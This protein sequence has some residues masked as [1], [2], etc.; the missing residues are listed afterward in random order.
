VHEGNEA[1]ERRNRRLGKINELPRDE[2][3]RPRKWATERI[4]H[5]NRWR[6]GKRGADSC[7]IKKVEREKKKSEKV[8]T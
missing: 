8:I 1:S 7:G 4:E 6:P 2:K 5:E 3:I